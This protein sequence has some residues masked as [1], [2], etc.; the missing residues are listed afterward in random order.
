MR[1]S[2]LTIEGINSF[3]ESQT[4]D[5]EAAGADNLFCISGSTGSGKTTIIDCIILALYPKHGER[6]NLDEYVNLR[7]ERGKISFRFLIGD[8]IYETERVLTRKKN[9]KNTYVLYKNG[10]P[11]AEGDEAFAAVGEMIGLDVKEFTNVVVLQQGE[12]SRFLKAKKADRVTLITKLF[13]L[14]RFDGAYSAFAVKNR[15]LGAESDGL[16]VAIMNAGDVT[17]ES[18]KAA[19]AALKESEENL[20]N[21]EKAAAELQKKR[22]EAK[23]KRAAFDDLE[24]KKQDLAAVEKAIKD[25]AEASLRAEKAGAEL[26]TRD[27]ELKVRESAR[28]GLVERKAAINALIGRAAALDKDEKELAEEETELK[29][30]KEALS[31]DEKRA[32][33]AREAYEEKKAETATALKAEAIRGAFDVE[34]N[35]EAAARAEEGAKRDLE[36]AVK[37]REE[38]NKAN[39]IAS[40]AKT[41]KE[42]AEEVWRKINAAHGEAEKSAAVAAAAAKTARENYDAAVKADALGTIMIGLH[43]GD[44]C[45]VCGGKIT[46]LEARAAASPTAAKAAMEQAEAKAKAEADRLGRSQAAVAAAAEKAQAAGKNYAE[47]LA[48]AAE[49][50]EKAKQSDPIKLQE[51]VAA[52][53]ALVRAVAARDEAE[54]TAKTLTENLARETEKITEKEKTIAERK[55]KLAAERQQVDAGL[56]EKPQAELNGITAALEKL[57]AERENLDAEKKKYADG[58]AKMKEIADRNAGRRESLIAAIE[59]IKNAAFTSDED[60]KRLADEA[61]EAA[62][63]AVETREFVVET[64]TK[65]DRAKTDLIKKNELGAKLKAKENERKKYAELEKLFKG[66]AFSEFV[67]AEY[68][69]DFTAAASTVL[70]EL[71][72][73]KYS[74]W[75]DEGEG[76]FYVRD[77]LSGN[78]PRGV[79]TLSGGET[80]LASLSLAIAISGMLSKDKN[81]EFFFIDEGF[82]TL[83][84]DA[85]DAV[86]DALDALS[87]KTMVGVITHRGELIERIRSVIK[88]EPSDGESG[89]KI[90][91]G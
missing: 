15:K 19:E 20:K 11:I 76:E 21:I 6:G 61:E 70:G 34:P 27:K 41:E 48:A 77:F 7:C 87:R 43:E 38:A 68:I 2:K 37:F 16:T 79:R 57:N 56:G 65:L 36:A 60:L 35:G 31:A 74:L 69:K 89:S 29:K 58:M 71:T 90:I 66:R 40:D 50:E 23:E 46:R 8:D 78:E 10:T 54:K 80:F 82:G 33:A 26:E 47:K 52:L 22:D 75:Y 55:Y 49:A 64:R 88:V 12:F 63:K 83:S 39:K 25:H 18:V 44:D 4:V 53:T 91:F 14:G 67:A 86:T 24:K 3:I 42:A 45:P 9:G 59:E 84:P 72:G 62:K 85:L 17:D 51:K 32:E 5:F 28:D 13:E 81:Y 73:G 1:P 30:A